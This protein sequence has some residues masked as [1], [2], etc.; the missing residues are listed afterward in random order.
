[1]FV[2]VK[3]MFRQKNTVVFENYNLTPIDMYNGLSQVY[4]IKRKNPFVYSFKFCIFF[5]DD[6]LSCWRCLCH[7]NE[8]VGEQFAFG[9]DPVG[10]SISVHAN[11]AFCLHSNYSMNHRSYTDA[12]L[13][14]LKKNI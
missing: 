9:M 10:I 5:L 6:N 11:I 8:E 12:S 3:K 13:G 2:K 14:Q 4:C 1:M 7:P